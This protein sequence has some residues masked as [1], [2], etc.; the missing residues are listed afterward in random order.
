MVIKRT[1]DL[2]TCKALHTLLFPADEFEVRG[3]AFWLAKDDDG[4]PAGFCSAKP[5]IIDD[6]AAFLSRAGVLP[7]ARGQGLQRRMIRTRLKWA[8]AEGFSRAIT[9][10]HISNIPSARNLIACGFT[11]YAPDYPF[12]GEDMI[13]F[14]KSLDN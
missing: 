3:V 11:V 8:R 13:Y 4:E 12:A 14:E 1:E 2:R 6:N 10:T 7:H 5:S 9:Y